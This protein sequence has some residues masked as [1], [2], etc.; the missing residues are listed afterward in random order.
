MSGIA[1]IREKQH[2]FNKLLGNN[3]SNQWAIIDPVSEDW[4]Y[5]K[6]KKSQSRRYN[7]GYGIGIRKA[8]WNTKG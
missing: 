3:L 7:K 5:R 4:N 1:G 6:K 2:P 8:L